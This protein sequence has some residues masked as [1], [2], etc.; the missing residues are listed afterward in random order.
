MKQN[1]LLNKKHQLSKF[2]AKQIYTNMLLCTNPIRK[3]GEQYVHVDVVL[4]LDS[5]L[6]SFFFELFLKGSMDNIGSISWILSIAAKQNKLSGRYQG[7]GRSQG[8]R[9]YTAAEEDPRALVSLKGKD[10]VIDQLVT[11]I[12]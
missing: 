5:L 11:R 3:H 7:N 8:P 6:F 2:A 4:F 9:L 10:P 1:L 12:V